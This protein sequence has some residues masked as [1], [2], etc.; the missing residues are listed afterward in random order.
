MMTDAEYERFM[1]KTHRDGDCLLWDGPLD[2]DGYGHFYL[3]RRNRGSHRV[4]WW[5]V[6]G[7]IPDG[8]VVNHKC[9]NRHCVNPQ[10][11]E[12][13]TARENSLRDSTSPAALNARKV[14]CPRGHAY[15][16]KY[17]RQRYCSICEREKSRR[18]RAKW[19]AADTVKC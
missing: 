10:H 18:L 8:M 15:D 5:N 2:K 4:A 6:R 17:G 1:S 12:V 3:R 16:R 19:I 7:D 13:I 11:L 14:M 9:R